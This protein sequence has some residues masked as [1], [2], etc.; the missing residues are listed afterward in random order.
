MTYAHSLITGVVAIALAVLTVGSS[1]GEPVRAAQPRL[2][3]DPPSA[4]PAPHH[5]SST[6]WLCRP[7]LPHNPCEANLTTTVVRPDGGMSVQRVVHDP[8]AR[9]R[10]LRACGSRALGTM[11]SDQ[12]SASGAAP[13]VMHQPG[14]A[15]RRLGCA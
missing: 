2:A 4:A 1:Q 11:A 8:A 9:S 5:Q 14:R 6:V 3:F 13:G 7:R 12:P 15:R 10:L